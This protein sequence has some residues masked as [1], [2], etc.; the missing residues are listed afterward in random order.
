ME[1]F[2]AG[3]TVPARLVLPKIVLA[4]FGSY[5]LYDNGALFGN[6][7]FKEDFPTA[8]AFLAEMYMEEHFGAMYLVD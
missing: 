3:A 6:P 5:D 8:A 4:S 7:Y 1:P 2:F